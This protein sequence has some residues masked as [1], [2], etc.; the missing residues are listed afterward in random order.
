M[1]PPELTQS[2]E[3]TPHPKKNPAHTH[4]CTH[5]ETTK[6]VL[7]F[8]ET[9]SYHWTAKETIEYG[10]LKES[11]EIKASGEKNQNPTIYEI[12]QYMTN[13]NLNLTLKH[14]IKL[15]DNKI[16][17]NVWQL[18]MLRISSRGVDLTIILFLCMAFHILK[19]FVKR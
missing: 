14:K 18:K 8:I 5:R 7:P 16:M 11:V 3:P 12:L 6:I 19:F 4:I 17:I 9:A 13:Y 1:I 2:I 10:L 15:K